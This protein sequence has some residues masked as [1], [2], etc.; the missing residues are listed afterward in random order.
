[1]KGFPGKEIA[2][3]KSMALMR[4]TFSEE[5]KKNLLV[6]IGW[7]TREVTFK[8]KAKK[9]SQILTLFQRAYIAK[10]KIWTLCCGL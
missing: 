1:M 3:V 6:A 5:R 8:E 10:N 9:K 2:C 4:M 7:G